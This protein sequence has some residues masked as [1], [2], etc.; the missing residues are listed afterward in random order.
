MTWLHFTFAWESW[1]YLFRKLYLNIFFIME[2]T[3]GYHCFSIRVIRC[4]LFLFS[5]LQANFDAS[6]IPKLMWEFCFAEMCF[7]CCCCFFLLRNWSHTTWDMIPSFFFLCISFMTQAKTKFLWFSHLIGKMKED[8][9][10]GAII[11]I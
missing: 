10:H 11:R 4:S 1:F 9:L 7:C 2:R 5:A 6:L 3:L 8:M